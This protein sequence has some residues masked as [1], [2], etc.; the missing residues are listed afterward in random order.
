M[1]AAIA[2]ELDEVVENALDV[3]ERVRTLL[4]PG[5]ENR[6]PDVVLAGL[7]ADPVELAL[8]PAQL[9]RDAGTAQERQ[10]AELR[11]ALAKPQLLRR[12]RPPP[13][14]HGRRGRAAAPETA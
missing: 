4:V 1:V 8:Q 6:V 7:V 14:R 13:S 12:R 10:V 2:V 5:Q 9:G 3:V 11:Q